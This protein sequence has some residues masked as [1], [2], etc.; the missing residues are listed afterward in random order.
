MNAGTQAEHRESEVQ[1]E[2]C[3]SAAQAK[4]PLRQ[5]RNTLCYSIFI[6]SPPSKKWPARHAAASMITVRRALK[7]KPAMSSAS[8]PAR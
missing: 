8:L 2:G 5:I 1:A 6:S 4:K 3:T 7:G